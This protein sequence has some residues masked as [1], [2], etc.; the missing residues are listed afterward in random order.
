MNCKRPN[1]DRTSHR[2]ELCQTHY[3][4]KLTQQPQGWVAM[5]KVRAHIDS[6]TASGMSQEQIAT[7]ARVSRRSTIHA[8]YDPGRVKMRAV[9]ASRILAVKPAMP[10]GRWVCGV[11]TQR[12]LRSLMSVG[13]QVKELADMMGVI[14]QT[15]SMIVNHDQKVRSVTARAADRVFREL[16][17]TPAPDSIMAMRSRRRA[18]RE[19]WPPPLAWDLETIDDPSSLPNLGEEG[20]FEDY[21]NDAQELGH[22]QERMA[23]FLDI[24]PESLRQKIRRLE[25]A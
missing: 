16:Q 15:A 19:N 8:V 4:W 20:S 14:T 22:S 18:E 12:R 3:R 1:C 2:S 7:L 21:F 5:E 17:L 25:V 6:L 24:L 9:T 10:K 11:G 13:Y 23:E